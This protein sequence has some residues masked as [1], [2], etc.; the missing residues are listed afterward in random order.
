[1]TEITETGAAPSRMLIYLTKAATLGSC[2]LHT[3]RALYDRANAYGLIE[4][5]FGW[6]VIHPEGKTVPGLYGFRNAALEAV[7]NYEGF[8]LLPPRRTTRLFLEKGGRV[9]FDV[10]VGRIDFGGGSKAGDHM[11][12]RMEG[13]LSDSGI[14]VT[15]DSVSK[16]LGFPDGD[17]PDVEGVE[18]AWRNPPP[19]AN[20]GS[21]F[22][23]RWVQAFLD[24]K[25][26][27]A[28]IP[29][30]D[31]VRRADAASGH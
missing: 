7:A 6:K 11:R 2:I 8:P 28:L 13:R 20:N 10:T 5:P 23:I 24:L 31:P 27:E 18:I 26:L 21:A 16:R 14:S 1:M 17:R 22:A 9:L 30:L 29:S 4:T 15:Y 12:F 25:A 3:P 19:I